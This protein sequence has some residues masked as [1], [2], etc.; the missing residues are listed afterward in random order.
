MP[1]F[2]LFI[3]HVKKS[4]LRVTLFYRQKSW[5]KGDIDKNHEIRLQTINTIFIST[6]K[7]IT[8]LYFLPLSIYTS[9]KNTHMYKRVAKRIVKY[10]RKSIKNCQRNHSQITFSGVKYL[11][12]KL[13]GAPSPL[14]SVHFE[15]FSSSHHHENI[16]KV[17]IT[18][19][20]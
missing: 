20:N 6:L 17:I 4:G 8:C 10:F 3:E 1:N 9:Q 16:K 2:K 15:C 5:K 7:F 19:K 13:R 12:F 14:E 18:H 11:R